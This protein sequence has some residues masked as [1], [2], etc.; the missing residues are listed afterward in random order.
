MNPAHVYFVNE[1]E[2]KGVLGKQ[3]NL[4]HIVD[5]SL[6]VAKIAK[7]C[8]FE[9]IIF[10]PHEEFHKNNPNFMKAKNWKNFRKLL[11]KLPK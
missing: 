7:E 10:G 11:E 5:D 8:G 3:L 1:Y 2:D 4:T 9:P 6:K